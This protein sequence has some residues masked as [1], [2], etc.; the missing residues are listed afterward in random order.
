[1]STPLHKILPPDMLAPCFTALG[2]QASTSVGAQM[3]EL[4]ESWGTLMVRLLVA[5]SLVL[6]GLL[7]LPAGASVL[8]TTRW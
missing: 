4:E 7:C 3:Q 6:H 5:V 8:L 2:G 1:M